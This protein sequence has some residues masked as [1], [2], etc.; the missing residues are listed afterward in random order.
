M[1][2]AANA[3]TTDRLAH[4]IGAWSSFLAPILGRPGRPAPA[5][6]AEA[7]SLAAL[8][9]EAAAIGM[10]QVPEEIAELATFVAGLRPRHVMEIGCDRG[11]T[12]YLWAHLAAGTALAV[13]LPGGGFSTG[14]PPGEYAAIHRAMATWS[15]GARVVLGDSRSPE[16]AREVRDAL[17]GEPLDFLFIDGDHSYEGAR[18]DYEAYRRLVRPGGWV[19]L[20]DVA[21]SERHRSQGCEVARLWGE[22][23]GTKLEI[24]AGRGW[25]GIGLVQA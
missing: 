17:G 24:S 19:G 21:D 5:D 8:L 1:L 4:D 20:H 3:Y 9:A 25:A 14:L 7:A 18:A 10:G 6:P 13:D 11:G 15:P 12:F 23:G 16:V 2:D 22:I